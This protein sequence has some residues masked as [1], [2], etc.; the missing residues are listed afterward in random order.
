MLF[1]SIAKLGRA[2][3]LLPPTRLHLGKHEYLHQYLY[4]DIALPISLSPRAVSTCKVSLVGTDTAGI[5]TL[6][7]V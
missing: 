4:H 3:Q 6:Q 2:L 5:Q 1:Q 7:P